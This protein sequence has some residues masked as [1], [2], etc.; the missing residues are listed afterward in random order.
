MKIVDLKKMQ[1]HYGH[2]KGKLCKGGIV[3]EKETK[4]LKVIDVLT[5]QE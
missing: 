2:T 3:Q 1:Q 5:V 4:N